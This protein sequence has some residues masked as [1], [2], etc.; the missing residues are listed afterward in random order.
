MNDFQGTSTFSPYTSEHHLL[1]IL[2]AYPSGS[3]ITIHLLMLVYQHNNVISKL[4][5]IVAVNHNSIKMPVL[6]THTSFLSESL[7]SLSGI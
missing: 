2:L 4:F 5:E 7:K 6:T 3:D 1:N